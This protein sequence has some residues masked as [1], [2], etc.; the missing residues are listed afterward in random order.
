MLRVPD[1]FVQFEH[2]AISAHFV[3]ESLAYAVGFALYRWDRR[4]FGDAL[5]QSNRN[6]VI[7]AAVLGAACG[8]KLLAALEEPMAFANAPLAVSLGGKTMVGALLGGTLA[9]EWI[10]R[11]LGVTQRT[12]DLFAI[13]MCMAIA[14]GRVGCFFSGL[15]DHTFG[16]PTNLPWGVDFGDG[17]ARHPAQLYE[18]VFLL[19]LGLML[20]WLRR[21]L[22]P[23]GELFR[24]FL[25]SYLGWRLVIDFLKPEPTFAGLSAIQWACLLALLFYARDTVRMFMPRRQMQADG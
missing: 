11:R 18:I 10:K 17:I 1:L 24:V 6:S 23:N 25:V 2:F 4:R 5:D 15:S 3:F 16:S 21:R 19:L 20:S 7:V 14:I 8:S 22:P 13:P 12:G 9:V